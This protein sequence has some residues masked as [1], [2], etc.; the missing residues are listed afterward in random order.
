MTFAETTTSRDRS[1]QAP[2]G[3]TEEVFTIPEVAKKVKVSQQTIYNACKNGHLHHER[4]GRQTRITAPA[5]AE[6]RAAGGRTVQK[7]D[8]PCPRS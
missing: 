6:W 4:I 7:P 1:V 3:Q 8:A 2:T 5:I